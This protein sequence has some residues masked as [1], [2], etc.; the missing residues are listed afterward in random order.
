MTTT[1]ILNVHFIYITIDGD[2]DDGKM[3]MDGDS[4]RIFASNMSNFDI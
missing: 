4:E 2:V 1:T 3:M